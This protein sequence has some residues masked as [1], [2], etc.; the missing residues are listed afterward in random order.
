MLKIIFLIVVFFSYILFSFI[1]FIEK[2][3][4]KKQPLSMEKLKQ[5]VKTD[6]RFIIIFIIL[7]G[8]SFIFKYHYISSDAILFVSASLLCLL[9]IYAF[10]LHMF[11]VKSIIKENEK[12]QEVKD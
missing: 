8:A 2:K 4:I 5:L 3:E 6:K 1:S 9:P 11:I 10:S 12:E 7:S